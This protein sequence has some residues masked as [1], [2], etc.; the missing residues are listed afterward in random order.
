MSEWMLE[1]LLYVSTYNV[2][3]G[4]PY[5]AVHQLPLLNE[6]YLTVYNSLFH[7]TVSNWGQRF[8]LNME[9]IRVVRFRRKLICGRLGSGFFLALEPLN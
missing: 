1:S 3:V 2:Y 6:T 7:L 8:Y 9:E 5:S 4:L